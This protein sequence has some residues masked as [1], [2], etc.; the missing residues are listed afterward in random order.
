[1]FGEGEGE[2]E[3]RYRDEVRIDAFLADL[4]SS[5]DAWRRHDRSYRSYQIFLLLN[6]IQLDQPTA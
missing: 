3:G 5:G 2:E 6:I 1:M 4:S